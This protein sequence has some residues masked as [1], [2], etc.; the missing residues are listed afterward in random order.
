MI[1]YNHFVSFKGR[2]PDCDRPVYIYRNLNGDSTRLFSIKQDGLVVGH[3]NRM[4]LRDCTFL[5]S[6]AGQARVRATKTKNVH[7]YIRGTIAKRGAMGDDGT[8]RP[9]PVEVEYNPYRD[10]HFTC[11]NLTEKPF[12]V[13]AAMAAVVCKRGVEAAYTD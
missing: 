2:R 13:R 3:T 8:G 5:V 12:A 1:G 11:R 4:V 10:N 9:W 7:A 6:R